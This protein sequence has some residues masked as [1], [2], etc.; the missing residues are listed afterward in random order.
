MKPLVK[1]V[2]SDVSKMAGFTTWNCCTHLLRPYS[3]HRFGRRR[4]AGAKIAQGQGQP[5]QPAVF[6]KT[7][8]FFVTRA[9]RPQHKI[10]HAYANPA[11]R[12]H[13]IGQSFRL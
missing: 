10:I 9:L 12:T 4:D 13:E 7:N 11:K 5:H 3:I 6:R 1:E 8:A 2:K